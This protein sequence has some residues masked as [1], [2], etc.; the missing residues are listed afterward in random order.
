M[1]ETFI[2]NPMIN[3]LLL[4]YNLLGQNFVLAIAFFTILI[5]IITLPLNMRQQRSM[6][7]TQEMQ[8]QI[9]AIQKKYKDNP[10]K[11]QEEFRKIG[12]NP[13]DTLTGCLPTLLQFPILIGLYQSIIIV[14]G[15]TPQALFE[16]VPRTYPAINLSRLIPV[17]NMFLWLNLSQPDPFFILPVLV[18]VSMFVQ[19][20]LLTP[21]PAKTKDAQDNPMA[22]MTQSMQ[23][24]MPLMFGFFSLQFP[25]G[26][27]IYFILANLIGI[28]Q[29]LY[30][31]RI[32]DREK[33]ERAANGAVPAL[34]TVGD[35]GSS[36]S[37]A[38]KKSVRSSN[39]SSAGKTKST[40][41]QTASRTP[42]KRK[43]RSAKR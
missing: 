19:Q 23:Y 10:Q 16:L 27:S 11:M 2:V 25:S 40:R 28:G 1:W 3:A 43:K 4:F 21:T 15:T 17:D 35:D 12:Y 38:V 29:G 32:T 31:K 36:S 8:P 24:T 34:A 7:K 26:L 33:A 18:V 14:L 13:A 39:G 20:K 42:S 30:M 22:G 6:M 5:R 9:Q 37:P 41:T